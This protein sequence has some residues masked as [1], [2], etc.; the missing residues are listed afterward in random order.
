MLTG[1]QR[2]YHHVEMEGYAH[3]HSDYIDIVASD[4]LAGI[5]IGFHGAERLRG[6][7]SAC[8]SSRGNGRQSEL[9]ERAER[10][11]MCDFGPASFGVRPDQTNPQRMFAHKIS[12]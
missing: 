2:G 5:I 12:L 1:F 11:Y 4:E 8:Q 10:R 6:R 7:F 9:W 3:T